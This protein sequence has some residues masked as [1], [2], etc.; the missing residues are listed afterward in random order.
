MELQGPIEEELMNRAVERDRWRLVRDEVFESLA[1]LSNALK[2]DPIAAEWITTTWFSGN[3]NGFVD[4]DDILG[5]LSDLQK[6][7][8]SK[9]EE[10]EK[11]FEEIKAHYGIET[12]TSELMSKLVQQHH[13]KRGS[14]RGI[15]GRPTLR[16][17]KRQ[18]KLG[19]S[20]IK[21]LPASGL[22]LFQ[23]TGAVD[24][25][26]RPNPPTAKTTPRLVK[27]PVKE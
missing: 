27:R 6:Y 2:R 13:A 3:D 9:M 15:G 18:T 20:L 7:C 24:Q 26:V 4:F 11:R 1:H 10:T 21:P 22:P 23:P 12:R 17:I 25:E 5:G 14:K 19:K 16:D 8:E